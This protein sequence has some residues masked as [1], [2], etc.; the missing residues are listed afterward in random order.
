MLRWHPYVRARDVLLF[1]CIKQREDF[2]ARSSGID[3][4]LG[5][6]FFEREASA[7]L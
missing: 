1:K 2:C 5:G 4:P 7:S 3:L 6:Y